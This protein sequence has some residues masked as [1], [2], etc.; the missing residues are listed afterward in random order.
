MFN[1]DIRSGNF[2]SSQAYKLLSATT[3]A[4]YVEEKNYERLLG[5]SLGSEADAKATKWGKLLEMY[6]CQKDEKEGLSFDYVPMIDKTIVHPNIPF[7]VGSPDFKK[8]NDT[9]VELKCPFTKKAYCQYAACSTPD[10]FRKIKLTGEKYYW[11]TISGSVLLDVPYAEL[12]TYMPYQDELED[13]KLLAQ[14]APSE[15]VSKYYFIGMA[16]DGDLPYLKRGGFYKDFHV[17]RW[18]IDPDDKKKITSAML[19]EGEKLIQ[20]PSFQTI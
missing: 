14:Q 4:T 6:V 15:D 3:A 8:G 13:I 20:R 5:E 2:T 9:V 16:N 12:I 11:Q 1:E 19:K 17:I 7:W 10:E 18:E